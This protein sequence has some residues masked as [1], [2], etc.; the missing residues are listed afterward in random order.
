MQILHICPIY[1]VIT[2]SFN[3]NTYQSEILEDQDGSY[4]FRSQFDNEINYLNFKTMSSNFITSEQVEK[5]FISVLDDL[6]H[7]KNF[8]IENNLYQKIQSNTGD[9]IFC[10]IKNIETAC[11]LNN[12]DSLDWGMKL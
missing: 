10:N 4:Y 3:G 6:N 9:P 12:P 11:D 7:I 8:L 5:R 2:Y 1:S